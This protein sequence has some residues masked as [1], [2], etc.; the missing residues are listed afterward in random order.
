MILQNQHPA[1]KYFHLEQKYVQKIVILNFVLQ[2]EHEWC[3][4]RCAK[5]ST[6]QLQEPIQG[7]AVWF[8]SSV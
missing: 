6:N 4:P 1:V 5:K 2:R 3:T 7:I 8:C